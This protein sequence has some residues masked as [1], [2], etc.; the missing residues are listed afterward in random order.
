MS[1]EKPLEPVS[2]PFA[3]TRVKGFTSET[4]RA[5]FKVGSAFHSEASGGG[6]ASPK[7][8]AASPSA[9]GKKRKSPTVV[10]AQVTGSSESSPGKL[11]VTA[12]PRAKSTA[13]PWSRT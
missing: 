6:N 13:P 2:R 12:L 4:C 8:P 7:S 5:S 9:A 1:F 3:N 10:F 11:P